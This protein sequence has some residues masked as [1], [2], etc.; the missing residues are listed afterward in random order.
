M[1]SDYVRR[2]WQLQCLVSNPNT[3]PNT[4]TPLSHCLLR[5]ITP[6]T[7]SANKLDRI[8]SHGQIA[9]FHSHR[10]EVPRL[11]NQDE[12]NMAFRHS[13]AKDK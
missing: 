11:P 2:P 13:D 3:L 10:Q 8:T 5:L 12:N 1:G 7:P 4:H 9:V 6:T